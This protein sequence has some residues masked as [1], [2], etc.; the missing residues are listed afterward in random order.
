MEF[1]AAKDDAFDQGIEVANQRRGVGDR[2]L[3]P[4]F[5]QLREGGSLEGALAGQDFVED[6]A[7]LLAL[8]SRPASCSGAI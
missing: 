8:T 3:F 4:Q 7:E 6:E 1:E 2:S 5:N